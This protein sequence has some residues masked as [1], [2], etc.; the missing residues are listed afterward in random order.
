MKEPPFPPDEVERQQSLDRL[1]ILDTPAEERF[2]RITR[3]A[4][5]LF[6]VPTVLISLVDRDRQWFKSAQGLEASE[7]S[8]SVSFCGH[9]ILGDSTLVVPDARRDERFADNPL[10]LSGPGIRFYAGEPI[11]AADGQTVGTL[12][13]LDDRP[14]RLSAEAREELRD[15]AALVESELRMQALSESEVALRS[16]LKATE[17]KAAIDT[18]TRTWSR[19]MVIELLE[20]ELARCWRQRLPLGLVM[21]DL[22]DFKKVNDTHGH[23]IGDEVLRAAAGRMRSEIRPYDIV[24][25]Y[26]GEEFL[27]LLHA[28]GG[29]RV[30][31]AADR[32]RQGLAR[33]PI[34]TRAGKVWVTASLGVAVYPGDAK[35]DQ[36]ALI[37]AADR[38]LY[39]AKEN[40]KNRVELA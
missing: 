33:A 25:R 18:V 7:T 37:A 34:V 1:D 26:G 10:V 38:A 16:R 20:R 4:R 17:R 35:P 15:L 36:E 40:G 27:V 3:L 22:D 12:C 13:L 6:K 14:R 19:A 21:L 28:Q 8:R 23:P 30:E 5:R 9:A 11:R 2:D 39:E 24:G 32:I 31:A 29:R